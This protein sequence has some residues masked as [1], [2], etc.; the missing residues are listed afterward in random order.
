MVSSGGNFLV[1]AQSHDGANR[2]AKIWLQQQGSRDG[3]RQ[4]L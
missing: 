4:A 1:V 3:S 2:V